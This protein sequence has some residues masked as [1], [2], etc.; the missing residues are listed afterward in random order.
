MHARLHWF[1]TFIT[2]VVSGMTPVRRGVHDRHHRQHPREAGLGFVLVTDGASLQQVGD[3]IPDGR[4]IEP[5]GQRG[6]DR[7]F[8]PFLLGDQPQHRRRRLVEREDRGARHQVQEIP[9]RRLEQ[10][11][12]T[13]R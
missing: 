2:I 3:G 10:M 4:R 12:L 5:S 11:E 8:G 7:R 9:P 13:R 1:V 6:D